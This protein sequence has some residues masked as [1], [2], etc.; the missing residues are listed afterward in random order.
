MEFNKLKGFW[1]SATTKSGGGTTLG[2]LGNNKINSAN[3]NNNSSAPQSLITGQGLLL[4]H[5]LVLYRVPLSLPSKYCAS[6]RLNDQTCTIGQSKK[7]CACFHHLKLSVNFFWVWTNVYITWGYAVR[8]VCKIYQNSQ[9]KLFHL[10]RLVISIVFCLRPRFVFPVL[11][12]KHIAYLMSAVS[13]ES[14]KP[15]SLRENSYNVPYLDEDNLSV[16][17]WDL[18]SFS[19]LTQMNENC[20][21]FLKATNKS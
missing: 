3:A 9:H 5:G 16:T 1:K 6:C 8:R 21:S 4:R 7:I 11:L 2:Q 12:D 17:N 13:N 19:G 14:A 18:E 10:H 20:F 15:Y